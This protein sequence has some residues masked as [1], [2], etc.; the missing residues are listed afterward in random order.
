MMTVETF[1]IVMQKLISVYKDYDIP[2]TILGFHSECHCLTHFSLN[3]NV[4]VCVKSG[5]MQVQ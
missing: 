2:V 4:G 3:L 1:D 5:N